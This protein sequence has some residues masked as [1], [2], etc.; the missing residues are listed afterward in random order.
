MTSCHVFQIY[1]YSMI[2]FL[3]RN[4]LMNELFVFF[5]E[6]YDSKEKFLLF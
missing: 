6:K 1:V 2:S 4:I 5:M 3:E